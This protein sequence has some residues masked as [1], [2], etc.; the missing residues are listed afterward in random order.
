MYLIQTHP[1][2]MFFRAKFVIRPPLQQ[3]AKI[4]IIDIFVVSLSSN[5]RATRRIKDS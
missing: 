2:S 5:S 1:Y 3:I 4:Y